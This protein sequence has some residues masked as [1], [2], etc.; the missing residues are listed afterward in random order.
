MSPLYLL[1]NFIIY[2][3][4]SS[5]S[6]I[7]ILIKSDFSFISNNSGL[8]GSDTNEPKIIISLLLIS[9]AFITRLWIPGFYL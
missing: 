9:L 5:S 7:L 4:L 3:L 1:H 2:L 8:I 6:S